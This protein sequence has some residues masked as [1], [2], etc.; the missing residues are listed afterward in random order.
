MQL[1]FLKFNQRVTILQTVSI[2]L[3]S[4]SKKTDKHAVDCSKTV[5]WGV[6]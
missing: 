1:F 4:D 3:G 6:K 5:C 2:K